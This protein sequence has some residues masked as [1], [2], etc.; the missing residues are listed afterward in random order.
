MFEKRTLL[1]DRTKLALQAELEGISM[2]CLWTCQHLARTELQI[3][4]K[5]KQCFQIPQEVYTEP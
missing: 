2:V 1:E 4:L 5:Q 3:K